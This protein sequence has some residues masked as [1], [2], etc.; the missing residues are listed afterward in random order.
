M[1]SKEY[2]D[3]LIKKAKAAIDKIEGYNQEQVDK[4][5]RAAGKIVL[6]NA[7]ALS[8]EAVEETHFGSVESKVAKH[9]ALGVMWDYLKGKKSVGVIDY[10]PI[11]NVTTIAK[12]R[13][14]IAAVV[15]STN[16]TTTSAF[17]IMIGLKGRNAIIVAPHP[18]AKKCT[19][20][21]VD[22]I[23]GELNKLGAPEGLVQCIEEPTIELTGLLM[24]AADLIIATGG[25]GMVKA[26]YSSGTPAYGVGQGNLQVILDEDY[27]EIERMV[28]SII[29]SRTYDLGVLCT[30]EQTLYIPTA[31]REEVLDVFKAK[32][33][34]VLE[35]QS[36][37]DKIR[38]IIFP[39]NG[40]INRAIVGKTPHAACKILGV[41]IP[42]DTT[43]LLIE[44][45][46]F[47]KDEPLCREIMF[48]VLRFITYDKFED[49][50]AMGRTNLLI[51][52]AGHT[53]IIYST[54]RERIVYCGEQ[55]PVGR[56]L[57]E[58]IGAAGAGCTPENG[59]PPTL[60]LGGGTWGG[61]MISENLQYEQ[62]YNITKVSG[63]IKDFKTPT[64]EE[65]WD[66]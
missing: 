47:G 2:I 44:L 9:D 54:D 58:Q 3:S 4:M 63:L 50:C 33:C 26:A 20:H 14:V 59:L 46:K 53:S 43:L 52:G 18:N 19:K 23:V 12:P 57:V 28:L 62:M 6:D 32:G 22:L 38:P 39:D 13:G 1:S 37:I 5:V 8:N 7:R 31:R 40:P 35:D 10:D 42:E 48:P 65:T 21:T 27:K 61:N 56:L 60:T 15:P 41:D 49:A 36:V 45:K 55:L 25:A 66:L 24:G 17:N 29:G 64:Y 34:Y 30:G 16:P 51:E 11:E